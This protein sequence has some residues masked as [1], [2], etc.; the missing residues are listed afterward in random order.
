MFLCVVCRCVH[1]SSYVCLRVRMCVQENAFCALYRIPLFSHLSYHVMINHHTF[2]CNKC[3][4]SFAT[5]QGMEL[6]AASH[7]KPENR[8]RKYECPICHKSYLSYSSLRTHKEIHMGKVRMEGWPQRC[9]SC[10]HAQ[11]RGAR[12]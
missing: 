6:H 9:S 3:G 11:Y 12:L 10:M 1:Q 7:E 5:K 2:V 8:E 4:K